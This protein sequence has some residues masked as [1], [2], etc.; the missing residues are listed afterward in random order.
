MW[1]TH[2]QSSQHLRGLTSGSSAS[3]FIDSLYRLLR[4][5]TVVR[6]VRS[7]RGRLVAVHGET[8][9]QPNRA[10]RRWQVLVTVAAENASGDEIP[11]PCLEVAEARRVLG[12]VKGALPCEKLP[13]GHSR[14]PCGSGSG[15]RLGARAR[16]RPLPPRA[17]RHPR[18]WR[19]TYRRGA[20]R[21]TVHWCAHLSCTANRRIAGVAGS[22]GARW[23]E[24]HSRRSCAAANSSS[25]VRDST[26]GSSASRKK[27][28]GT[29]SSSRS[30]SAR[31]QYAT[32]S[33][34]S[35]RERGGAASSASGIS[36]SR[37]SRSWTSH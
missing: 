15:S 33:A 22:C 25:T 3:R 4:S 10:K 14:G 37:S 9:A 19:R 24:R 12:A 21:S 20:H 8:A 16:R 18:C 34:S 26:I 31:T 2:R 28:A 36:I 5:C 6:L 35:W 32:T 7:R 1:Q 11:E 23:S 27:C 17:R 13:R 29:S 30:R